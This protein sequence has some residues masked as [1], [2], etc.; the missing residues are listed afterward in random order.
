MFSISNV[1]FLLFIFFYFGFYLF[2]YFYSEKNVEEWSLGRREEAHC[3][4]HKRL[5]NLHYYDNCDIMYAI[6]ASGW[7]YFFEV[8]SNGGVLRKCVQWE[9]TGRESRFREN[10]DYFKKNRYF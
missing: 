7:C 3:C 5:L 2:L 9:K 6:D 10:L 1:I 8:E 4:V